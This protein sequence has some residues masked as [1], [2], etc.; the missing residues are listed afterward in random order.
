V[1]T[2]L[3]FSG[4]VHTKPHNG[5]KNPTTVDPVVKREYCRI[6]LWYPRLT[7]LDNFLHVPTAF[8]ASK[9]IHFPSPVIL[10]QHKN[11]LPLSLLPLTCTSV[12]SKIPASSIQA[13]TSSGYCSVTFLR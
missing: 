1:K 13:S 10:W 5:T 11:Q 3:F 12:C 9:I 8:T 7:I 6:L 4:K 2:T